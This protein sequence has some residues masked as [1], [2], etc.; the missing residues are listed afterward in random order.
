MSIFLTAALLALLVAPVTA[1]TAAA[2]PAGNVVAGSFVEPNDPLRKA[3]ADGMVLNRIAA[4]WTWSTGSPE[5]TVAVLDTGVSPVED[6]D[7]GRLLPGRNVVSDDTDTTDDQGHGTY[8]AATI[9]GEADNNFGGAGVCWTCKILPVK[10]SKPV[11]AGGTVASA[12]VAAGIVWAADHGA[13]IIAVEVAG[14]TDTPAMRAAVAHATTAGALIVAPA[15]NLKNTV[16]TFPASIE[17][18]LAVGG[19]D[20]KG[21]PLANASTNPA[22][23]PWIDITAVGNRYGINQLGERT[24]YSSSHAATALVAGTAA[25]LLSLKP[26]ATAAQVRAA[27][28]D[29]SAT[30]ATGWG[31]ARQLDAGKATKT[32]GPVDTMA[33]IVTD[34]GLPTD[35][36]V[37]IARLYAFSPT[38]VD[39]HDIVRLELVINGKVLAPATGSPTRLGWWT[40]RGLDGPVDV[41]VR[42][43]DSSSNVGSNSVTVEFD[44]TEPTV[45]FLSPE[46][47]AAVDGLTTFSVE[48]SADLAS[49]EFLGGEIDT[50]VQPGPWTTTYDFS[51]LPPGW[52]N[53]T[54]NL[55]DR[56]GNLG[57]L[58]QWVWIDHDIP[59]VTLHDEDFPKILHGPVNFYVGAE[60][61]SLTNIDLIIDGQVVSSSGFNRRSLTWP[62]AE[63]LTGTF[64]L[65]FKATDE[66]GH[67][68]QV[69][70]TVRVDNTP[71]KIA[72]VTPANKTLVR[73]TF[74]ATASGV[75]DASGITEVYL[76]V[77]GEFAARDT[78]APY[79][80]PVKTGTR[81]G[82]LRLEW[83]AYDAVG[84]MTSV[85]RTINADNRAPTVSITKAPKNK[86]KVKGKITV[87]VAAKDTNGIARVELLVNGKIVATDKT[88]AYALT[89]NT[90]KLAKKMKVQV[91][92]YDKAGNSVVSASRTW[93]RS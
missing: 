39:D 7:D 71:P 63:K 43:Y 37:L 14:T 11:S 21:K 34:T 24:R 20:A 67:T 41:T 18:V 59:V 82:A 50:T 66:A 40:P 88:A 75:T 61:T 68:S 73:G 35:G 15:G 23:D 12:D 45:T 65:T 25:L 92:A 38:V 64:A 44:T 54:V 58:Y 78:S 51:S 27:L 83:I 89:V 26:D 84:N 93:Y 31:G 46:N 72:A 80:F 17:P 16:A 76:L 30:A 1:T 69:T 62:G 70:R 90:A 4:A 19:T 47:Y 91:R 57:G 28:L 13:D 48:G 36:T 55:R 77:N 5:V 10:V 81:T 2:A 53:F 22:T 32:L 42:A 6:L 8:I 29:G 52:F 49:L 60:D 9:A 85:Y 86:A 33:P 3:D 79:R 87:R 56:A 74:T